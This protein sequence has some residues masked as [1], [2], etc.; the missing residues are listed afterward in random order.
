MSE[1]KEKRKEIKWF[2]IKI[3]N[4]EIEIKIEEW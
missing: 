1:R 3:D 2:K 4:E